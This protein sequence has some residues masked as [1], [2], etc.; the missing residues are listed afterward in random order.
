[1]YINTLCCQNI[2]CNSRVGVVLGS[3]VFVVVSKQAAH[4]I[5]WVTDFSMF[6]WNDDEQRLQV[7]DASL[8]I[9]M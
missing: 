8:S 2:E 5:L 4:E 1:M 6:E 9:Y 3:N 7:W